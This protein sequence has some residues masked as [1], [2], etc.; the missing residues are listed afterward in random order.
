MNENPCYLGC[1][2]CCPLTSCTWNTSNTTY[3][4]CFVGSNVAP[5]FQS[6]NALNLFSIR[7]RIGNEYL[8]TQPIADIP[9]LLGELKD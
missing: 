7:L 3:G 2:P 8:L 9:T 1:T 5:T 6:V 4:S